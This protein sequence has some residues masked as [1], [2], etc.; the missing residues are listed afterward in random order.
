M[1]V[2]TVSGGIAPCGGDNGYV[3]THARPKMA[4]R[5]RISSGKIRNRPQQAAMKQKGDTAVMSFLYEKQA[6][7]LFIFVA[8][9]CAAQICF[10]G[11]SGSLQARGLRRALVERELGAASYLL[12]QDISPALL[13]AAWNHREATEE[14]RQLLEMIGHTEQTRSYLLLLA[15]QTSAPVILLLAGEGLLFSAVLLFGVG[16]FLRRREQIYEEAERVIAQ[17]AEGRFHIH[18][19]EGGNGTL[20]HLFGQVEQLAQSLQSKSEAEGR[21]KE[22][23]QDM[24]SNISHQLKTPLA[25]MGMYMEILAEEAGNPEAVMTFSRKSMCSLERMEQLI[26]ALLKMARLDTG[27][28]VFEKRWCPVAEIV[29]QAVGE[30]WERAGQE[31]KEILTE[32][33]PEES[34]FCDMEW[35]REAVGN[36]V[37]N[38]L[39]H[40]AAGGIVRIAWKRSPA[41]LR[42]TVADDGC[43]IAPDDI[44]HIF[45]RFYRSRSSSDRQG[46]GLGLSL[47]KSIVEGQ[48][49]TLSVESSPGEGSVFSISFPGS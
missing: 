4:L 28:I 49:G 21:A 37:K 36:L 35:T 41:L 44:H 18:L 27:N 11:F 3:R 7:G 2:R 38:A 48:G 43:G 30:L 22:F 46:A 45:K 14:G 23:L 5:I 15:G 26:Q 40:T 17:Y 34:I 47:A 24:I 31:H 32:G 19:P 42:L 16:L 25:A 1:A 12:E 20:C 39:D 6:R 9:V 33:M 29:A 8:A 10:M 13:A